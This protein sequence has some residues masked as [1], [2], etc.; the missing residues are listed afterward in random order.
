MYNKNS[1]R[2]MEIVLNSN[3]IKFLTCSSWRGTL[4]EKREILWLDTWRLW[5][6]GFQVGFKMELQIFYWS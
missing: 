2:G 1:Y 6:V 4:M 3:V 5:E